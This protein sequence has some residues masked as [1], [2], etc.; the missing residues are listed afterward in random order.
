M[1]TLKNLESKSVNDMFNDFLLSNEEMTC[2]RGGNED[3]PTLPNIPPV[4]I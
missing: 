3:N 2:V 4:I 1:R